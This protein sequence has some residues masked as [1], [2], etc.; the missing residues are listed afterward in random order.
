MAGFHRSG[1]SL[2]AQ[3]LYLSGV[4]A[5]IELM[6][7]DISNPDGHF[8]DLVAMRMH[9]DFLYESGCDWQYAGECEIH[10]DSSVQERIKQYSE[11]RYQLDG[12]VWLMKD[13]RAALYLDDWQEALQGNGKFV[14]MYRHWGL[15]IQSL[16]KRHSRQMA[17]GLRTGAALRTDSAFWQDPELAARMWLEYNKSMIEFIRANRECCLLVSLASLIQGFDL[18]STINNKFECQIDSIAESPVNAKYVAEA[19]DAIVLEGISVELKA[20][21]D[22]VYGQLVVLSDSE[23]AEE[24][25]AVID[26]PYDEKMAS[27]IFNAMKSIERRKEYVDSEPSCSLLAQ[28]SEEYK[29]LSFKELQLK[30][31]SLKPLANRPIAQKSLPFALRLIELEPFNWKGHEW[32]GRICFALKQYKNAENYFVKA[33]ALGNTPPYMKMLLADAYVGSYEFDQA[34][35][36]YLLA[37]K[38]NEK[39]PQ[40]PIKLADLYCKIKRYE[41]A[42]ENYEAALELKENDG[43]KSKLIY[44]VDQYRGAQSALECTDSMITPNNSQWLNKQKVRLKLKLRVEGAKKSYFAVIKNDI[45]KDR[46]QGFLVAFAELGLQDKSLQQVAYWFVTHY[47]GLFSNIEIT[48]IFN[49]SKIMVEVK[50]E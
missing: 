19:V 34:E 22:E 2:A 24:V 18:I 27:F 42:I 30:L 23:N 47:K 4:P 13:P 35:Y 40:F 43:V 49:N 45:N 50:Q 12:P 3:M 7:G 41:C 17:Y 28:L 26:K 37:I 15:C 25:P 10:H 5:A 6:G 16:L 9:D 20:E 44:A 11:C 46:V 1:T 32:S 36:L 29:N 33:I 48:E 8:E 31:E 38:G 39:N 14:L 21:L